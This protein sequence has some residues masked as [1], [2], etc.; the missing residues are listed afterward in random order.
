MPSWAVPSRLGLQFSRPKNG[1]HHAQA[2]GQGPVNP[3]VVSVHATAPCAAD[4]DDFPLVTGVVLP[5]G[6]PPH[7]VTDA[8]IRHGMIP[9]C[10]FTLH[11]PAPRPGQPPA[12]S[13]PR[14]PG[15]RARR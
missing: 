14:T 8:K 11:R 12:A 13:S 10:R 15:T 3:D 4:P 1:T 9:P 2:V 6:N 5:R 7:A